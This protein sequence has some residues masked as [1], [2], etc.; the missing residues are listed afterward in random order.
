MRPGVALELALGAPVADGA[1]ADGVAAAVP[2]ESLCSAKYS[3][4]GAARTSAPSAAVRIIRLR[5]CVDR[6]E[7]GGAA[8]GS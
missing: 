7:G 2:P 8:G 3:V 4:G 1:L 6:G 5:R